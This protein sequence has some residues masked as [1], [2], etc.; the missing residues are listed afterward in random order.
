MG[1]AVTSC[2]KV[3][4]WELFFK[5]G[6]LEISERCQSYIGGL[7]P[8]CFAAAALISSYI[9][10]IFG[11]PPSNLSP[12]GLVRRNMS[13]RSATVGSVSVPPF[14]IQSFSHLG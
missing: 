5:S 6:T 10:L 4:V 1:P 8:R 12:I 13:A 11:L 7:A 14:L 3:T 2:Q 9:G